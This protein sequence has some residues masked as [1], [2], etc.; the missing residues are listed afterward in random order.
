MGGRELGLYLLELLK[1]LQPGMK[2]ARAHGEW[3]SLQS[4]V[5]CNGKGS[6]C[7]PGEQHKSQAAVPAA[8]PKGITTAV[9]WIRLAKVTR[10][11]QS[12]ISV[13][14]SL[15]HFVTACNC[16]TSR[17]RMKALSKWE[18]AAPTHPTG[19]GTGQE[20]SDNA[21]PSFT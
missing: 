8:K 16:V 20:C 15:E 13:S 5:A 11:V 17:T 1:L 4:L 6:K 7:A 2:S 12:V 10:C 14:E 9:V 3:R 21:R 18:H 19:K